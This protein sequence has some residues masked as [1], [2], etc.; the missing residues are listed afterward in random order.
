MFVIWHI[1]KPLFAP[2]VLLNWDKLYGCY[3]KSYQWKCALVETEKKN[4]TQ[5]VFLRDWWQ[6]AP[7]H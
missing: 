2:K 6:W 5:K 7:Y 3:I 1:I 4:I